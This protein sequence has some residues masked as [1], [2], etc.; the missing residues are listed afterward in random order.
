VRQWQW[1]AVLTILLVALWSGPGLK[2][3][4][5]AAGVGVLMVFVGGLAPF[6]RIIAGAP[7]TVLRMIFSRHARFEMMNQPDTHPYKVLVRSAFNP[8]R[9]LFW[10]GVLL[11]VTFI[12]A[13]VIHQ[14]A[15]NLYRRWR[16]PPAPPVAGP[17]RPVNILV[18]GDNASG[19]GR[20]GVPARPGGIRPGMPGERPGGKPPPDGVGPLYQVVLRYQSFTGMGTPSEKAKEALASLPGYVSES[21]EI[22][23]PEKFIRFQ[24][25]GPSSPAVLVPVFGRSGFRSLRVEI[26]RRPNR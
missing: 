16:P 26:S 22:D 17:L 18:V 14:S 20:P 3:A 23:E 11:I 12:P 21:A 7:E 19:A 4:G 10:R 15:T 2:I 13:A 5:L 6:L 1:L 9:G 8:T 24:H 25:R